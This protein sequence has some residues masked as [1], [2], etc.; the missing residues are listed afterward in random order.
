MV[1]YTKDRKQA[2][3]TRL[4]IRALRGKARPVTVGNITFATE[5]DELMLKA[6][7]QLEALHCRLGGYRVRT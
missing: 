1:K 6:A 4:Y 2:R 5:H 3:L 7:V